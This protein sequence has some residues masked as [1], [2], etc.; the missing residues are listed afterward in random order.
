MFKMEQG[1]RTTFNF[2]IRDYQLLG[3]A[4]IDNF[5][6]LIEEVKQF[7]G[8]D[9]ALVGIRH[10]GLTEGSRAG[11]DVI[12]MVVIRRCQLSITQKS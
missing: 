11:V 7:L 4:F 2:A 6:E 3:I 1:L 12:S 9:G 5:S 10:R 8:I